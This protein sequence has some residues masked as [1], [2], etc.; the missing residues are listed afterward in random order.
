MRLVKGANEQSWFFLL[1][2]VQDLRYQISIYHN[3][4]AFVMT[5]S[6]GGVTNRK[7]TTMNEVFLQASG[8]HLCTWVLLRR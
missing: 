5:V 4:S 1:S 6:V 3:S 8:V 7:R 2:G